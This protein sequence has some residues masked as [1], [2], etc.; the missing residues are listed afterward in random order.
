MPIHHDLGPNTFI[1]ALIS[2][3][4]GSSGSSASSSE[5]QSH[6]EVCPVRCEEYTAVR[7]EEYAAVRCEEFA[8]VRCEEFAAVRCEDTVVRCDEYTD[9][10]IRGFPA[11]GVRLGKEVI[12]ERTRLPLGRQSCLGVWVGYRPEILSSGW[13]V[14]RC[15]G[16]SGPNWSLQIAG[17]GGRPF[18]GRWKVRRGVRWGDM[19]IFFL[20]SA[21]CFAG[22]GTFLCCFLWLRLTARQGRGA[23][24]SSRGGLELQQ[25][26][27]SVLRSR[28]V[29]YNGEV[30]GRVI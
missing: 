7:C 4:S 25:P 10:D 13:D 28:A 27:V 12:V 15:S 21:S 9:E 11:E 24:S 8:A 20:Y 17:I 14:R 18:L 5:L 22:R 23:K 1:Q 16:G 2:G 29:T 30:G 3:S 6:S 19:R 26:I